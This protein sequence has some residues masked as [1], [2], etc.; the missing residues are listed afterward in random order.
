MLSGLYNYISF[1]SSVIIS[2][3]NFIHKKRLQL[4]PVYLSCLNL[5][6]QARLYFW[7]PLSFFTC[8][9]CRYLKI[10]KSAW[11]HFFSLIQLKP[12][13]FA[14][15]YPIL[16]EGTTLHPVTQFSTWFFLT[17]IQL[18]T[19]SFTFISETSLN[20]LFPMSTTIVFVQFF[21]FCYLHYFSRKETLTMPVH[22]VV[23][24]IFMS[25]HAVSHSEQCLR[26]K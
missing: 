24:Q 1:P 17:H 11:P 9:V 2:L 12:L 6:L 14:P 13:P 3:P 15:S 7:S 8:I 10:M 16:V 22:S 20:W 21:I 25:T 23:Y 26:I 19:N 18:V 5:L 4:L